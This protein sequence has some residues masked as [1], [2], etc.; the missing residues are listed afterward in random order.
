MENIRDKESV[1][2]TE[3]AL[4]EINDFLYIYL[5]E[6]KTDEELK[7]DYPQLITAIEKGMLVFDSDN[8]MKPTFT[9]LNPVFT[10]DGSVDIDKIV[11]RTRMKASDSERIFKGINVNQDMPKYLNILI[12]YF[13]QLKSRSYL[14]KISKF[15]KKVI[16]QV[17]TVFP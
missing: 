5:F 2:S 16:E 8:E 10:D 15:D 4:K 13:A 9:L 7:E 6:D 14:D 1:I 3:V 12:S 11:F 17:S